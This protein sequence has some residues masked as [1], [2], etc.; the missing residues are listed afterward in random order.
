MYK[1]ISASLQIDIVEGKWFMCP[2]ETLKN[3]SYL[4]PGPAITNHMLVGLT[5]PTLR[6]KFT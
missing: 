3:V 1:N 6:S 2:P 4:F 5:L